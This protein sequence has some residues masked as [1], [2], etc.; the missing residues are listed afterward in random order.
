MVEAPV[1]GRA[2]RPGWRGETVSVVR[3]EAERVVYDVE[4]ESAG[5]LVMA[6]AWYPGWRAT[7]DGAPA[8]ILRANLLYRA[9]ALQPG[10]SRVELTYEPSTWA[11]GR[12]I[13]LATLAALLLVLIGDASRRRF[14]RFSRVTL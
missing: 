3:Y 1:A 12:I 13:S 7:V 11:T 5:L 4:S 8:Q 14:T 2:S 10:R 9:I 6:D